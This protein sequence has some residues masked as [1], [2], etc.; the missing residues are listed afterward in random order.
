MRYVSVLQHSEFLLFSALALHMA[1]EQFLEHES[2]DVKL[3]VAC[4]LADVFRIFAPNHPFGNSQK[5]KVCLMKMASSSVTFQCLQNL[6][7]LYDDCFSI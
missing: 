4:I 3:L 7:V 6:P 1:D 2:K 5:L